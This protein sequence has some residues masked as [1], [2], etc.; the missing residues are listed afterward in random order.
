M[1]EFYLFVNSDDSLSVNEDNVGSDFRINLPRSYILEGSWECALMELSF[2]PE[3]EAS[4]R[5]IYICS[6]LVDASYAKNT[7]LPI[8]RSVAVL[9]EEVTD[10][11]FDR[12]IYIK[13]R[14]QEVNRF[15][16]FILDDNLKMCHFKDDHVYCLLH[17]RR[18]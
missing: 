13:V 2:A 7:S 3:L 6:D 17:F 15:H 12:P 16:M 10:M 8:L 18:K 14:Q 1:N 11:T 5:R 4:T 9:S